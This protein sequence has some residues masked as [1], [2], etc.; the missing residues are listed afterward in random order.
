MEKVIVQSAMLTSYVPVDHE[1]PLIYKYRDIFGDPILDSLREQRKHQILC[2][3]TIQC[4]DREI[5]AHR[6]VLFP[7][8][9]YCR[10]L[11]TSSLSPTFNNGV[12]IMDLKVFSSDTVQIFIDLIYGENT[13]DVC[14]VDAEELMR[15]ADFLQMPEKML[16]EVMRKIINTEN[17][18]D[19][20]ELSLLY[21]CFPLQKVLESYICNILE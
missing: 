17:C 19:L 1:T 9:K 7:V 14:D 11:F 20:L 4:Q 15:L 12:L 3:V 10:T 6:C 21:N 18:L 5:M 8:S 2:D 13:S 16:T